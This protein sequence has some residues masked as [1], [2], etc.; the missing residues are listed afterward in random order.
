MSYASFTENQKQQPL[1]FC[2][3]T[4][5]LSIRRD[6]LSNRRISVSGFLHRPAKVKVKNRSQRGRFWLTPRLVGQACIVG[7]RSVKYLGNLDFGRIN[8]C[9][10]FKQILFYFSQSIKNK[11]TYRSTWHKGCR[12]IIGSVTIRMLTLF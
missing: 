3:L 8:Y 5:H 9:L 12:L 2:L 11:I 1:C 10:C 7:R 4:I 6:C